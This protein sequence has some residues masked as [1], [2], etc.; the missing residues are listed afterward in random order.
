MKQETLTKRSKNLSKS[1]Y[2]LD[3]KVFLELNEAKK[4]LYWPPLRFGNL[5]SIREQLNKRDYPSERWFQD[6]LLKRRVKGFLRNWPIANRFFVD[7]F[8]PVARIVIELDGKEHNRIVDARRDRIIKLYGYKVIRI[9]HYNDKLL[10]LTLDRIA[11]NYW[12]KKGFKLRRRIVSEADMYEF[13]PPE[14]IRLES[15]PIKPPRPIT[16]IL[17]KAAA[18]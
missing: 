16:T 1:D 4:V 8:F 5:N 7:F 3:E 15:A 6:E 2:I 9:N 18:I 17:R 10:K 12:C 13:F 14:V 11:S